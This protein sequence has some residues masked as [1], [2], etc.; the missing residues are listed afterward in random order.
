MRA[1]AR[2]GFT[3]VELLVTLGV[4]SLLI[5]LLLPAVQRARDAANRT[6]CSSNLR[7]IT[8]A[9]HQYHDRDGR[10]PPATSNVRTQ[11]FR[12]MNW[13]TRIL[14]FIE[15]DALWAA[16]TEAFDRSPDI[17]AVA[18]QSLH[19][20]S[21]RLFV[22]PSDRR[23]RQVKWDPGT[24]A[25]TSYLGNSGHHAGS[26]DGTLYLNSQVTIASITDGT[27]TT[28]LVGER[29]APTVTR[30]SWYGGSGLVATGSTD[31]HLGVRELL[32][33]LDLPYMCPTPLHFRP[34]SP[35]APCAYLH[36]WSFHT[37]GANFAFCDGSV[38]FLTYAADRLL[39]VYA[40]RGNGEI[41][42]DP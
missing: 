5:G 42:E 6:A 11:P 28:L 22:C 3:L 2:S 8:L 1:P 34:G 41:A 18:H 20:Q 10:F 30:G 35:N 26:Q 19:T 23:T 38:R 27:S 40:T 9:L 14:P 31:S 32:Q 39:P 29:P 25:V 4:V 24:W 17:L 21:V 16:A 13:H 12:L 33:D 15:Q 36:Y 37:G 7:Q